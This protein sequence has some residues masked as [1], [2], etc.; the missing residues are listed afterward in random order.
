[1]SQ[2]HQQ[3][4][5]NKRLKCFIGQRNSLGFNTVVKVSCPTKGGYCVVRKWL[6][7]SDHSE[8]LSL[9]ID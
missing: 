4:D 7:E 3:A 6:K 1:M 2:S 8:F 9:I 5:A